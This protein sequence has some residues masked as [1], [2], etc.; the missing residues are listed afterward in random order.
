MQFQK[1]ITVSVSNDLVTDQRVHKICTSLQ[2]AGAD[3]CLVGRKLPGSLPL[4]RKYQTKRLKLLFK[5]GALFYAC[6]NT[7]LFFFLLFKKTDIYLSN[8]LDTLLANFLASRLKRKMLVY[9]THEYFTGVPEI[10]DRKFVKTIWTSIERFIFPR[11][12][13]IY[14]VNG[15]IARLYREQ[16]NK[17][18]HV[19]RNVSPLYVHKDQKS[20]E[21][22][23]L[24]ADKKLIILQGSGIN[25][26]RG[27]EEA[28]EAMRHVNG[29]VLLILGGGDVL[30]ILRHL[31]DQFHLQEKVI[32]KPKMPYLGMMQ[33]TSSADIGL[34]LDKDTNINYR[35]SLPN[36]LFDYI[37]AGI[38]V[39]SSNLIEVAGIVRENDIGMITVSHDPVKIAGRITSMLQDD[40]RMSRWKQNLEVAAK[41]LCWENEEKKLLAIY[42]NLIQ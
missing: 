14:T 21:E 37:Q 24:P 18:V 16:Y 15:S 2:K 23:G 1:K 40:Q 7:R 42:Q 41:E 11:L 4:E 32:F 13:T 8:D 9:D 26:D 5:K 20:R 19:V 22:L 25:V 28:L 30:N 39:L 12:D 35:Y 34:T 6:F 38:P 27:A 36:K 29:A 10:Q 3:I 33:Y 17:E 31:V